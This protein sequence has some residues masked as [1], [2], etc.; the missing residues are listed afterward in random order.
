MDINKCIYRKMDEHDMDIFV[1]LRLVFLSEMNSD[2][3]EKN[4]SVLTESLKY[5]YS[6]YLP[7]NEFVGII[8]EY[9]N[10]VI[11]SAFLSLKEKPANFNF[12]NGRVGTILN[13]YTYP[14][15][16]KNGIS[17]KIMELLIFAP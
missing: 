1:E 16:R 2:L 7:A 12:V 10:K 17:T 11:S 15:Y 5:Y 14:E 9:D 6:K 4:K 13:V 3:T 8:C